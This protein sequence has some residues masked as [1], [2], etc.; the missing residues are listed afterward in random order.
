AAKKRER[1][2]YIN[3]F[4]PPLPF[5]FSAAIVAHRRGLFARVLPFAWHVAPRK[6]AARKPPLYPAFAPFAP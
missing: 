6:A 4:Q 5:S 2:G 1:Q 3:G